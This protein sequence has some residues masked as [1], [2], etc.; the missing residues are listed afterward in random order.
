MS[1]SME[2]LHEATARLRA[3]GWTE[4][5]DVRDGRVVGL[6]GDDASWSADEVRVC[7]TYRFEGP[8]DPGDESVLFAVELPG[9]GRGLLI[10]PYGPEV[11]AEDAEALRALHG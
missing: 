8:S 9:G 7:H 6:G 11:T 1:E 5:L 2:T 3:A 10:A 4:D